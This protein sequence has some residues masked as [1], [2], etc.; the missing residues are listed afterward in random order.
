MW[1]GCCQPPELFWRIHRSARVGLELEAEAG[2]VHELPVHLPLALAPLEPERPRD[3]QGHLADVRQRDRREHCV[4]GR[5][6]DVRERHRLGIEAVVA[7]RVADEPE[8]EQ[9][10]AL[11]GRQDL[12]GRPASVDLL[13]AVLQPDDRRVAEALGDLVE[14]DDDVHPLRHAD[15]IAGD[16][17]RPR[18]Q[19]AVVEITQNGI[20]W[21][22]FAGLVRK[23]S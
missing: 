15:A 10:V 22:R 21:L 19:V 13:Q 4:A 5:R 23:N 20:F 7:R 1:I 17:D 14:V 16:L 11:P 12:A 3:A 9:L 2:A 8:L 6:R 18:Q